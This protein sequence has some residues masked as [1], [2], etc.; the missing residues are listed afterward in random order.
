MGTSIR[1]FP[2]LIDALTILLRIAGAGLIALSFAH[3]PIGKHLK[4]REDASRLSP[5]NASIFRVHTLFIC[6][7]LIMMGLPCLFDPMVFLQ[8]SRAGG[9]LSWSFAAFWMTRLYV[10]W[11]VYQADLWRG[12]RME[13]FVH[14]WFTAIWSALALV[15]AACG[16]IQAG[17]FPETFR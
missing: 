12:K 6:L 13:S 3:I 5:V 7:V 11:F 14:Y 8:R 1:H 10:Q 15:F 9:W 16:F 4:W 17:W 2:N